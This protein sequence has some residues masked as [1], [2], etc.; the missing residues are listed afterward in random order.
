MVPQWLRF[1]A[2]LAFLGLTL[3]VAYPSAE[4]ATYLRHQ[5]RALEK[6]HDRL[7]RRSNGTVSDNSSAASA[8]VSS[9]ALADA[10]KLIDDMVTQQGVYN[11]YRVKNPRRNNYYAGDLPKPNSVQKKVRRRDDEPAPPTLNSTITAAAALL[12]EHHANQQ[13]S[14]GTLHRIY[15]MLPACFTFH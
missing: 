10:Q 13:A 6:Q 5:R 2:L 3:V 1:L 4:P 8:N 9:S 14:N 11:A 7:Y 15:S 12:A